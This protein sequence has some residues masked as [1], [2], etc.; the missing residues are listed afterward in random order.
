M[1]SEDGYFY[2][3]V[4]DKW[5]KDIE[6]RDLCAY[7][8]QSGDKTEAYQAAF[9]QGAGIAIAALATAYRKPTG[10]EFSAEQYLVSAE[11]AYWHLVEFNPSYCDDGQENIIDEYCALIAAVELYKSCADE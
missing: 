3:T 6:Q 8:N 5:S 1:L 7:E 11:K 4:F 10:G 2:M 9:R